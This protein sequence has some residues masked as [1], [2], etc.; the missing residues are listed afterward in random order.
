MTHPWPLVHE[1]ICPGTFKKGLLLQRRQKREPFSFSGYCY[2][3][4]IRTTKKHCSHKSQISTAAAAKSLQSCPTLSNPMDCRLPGSSIH[5]IFQ[6]RL[7]EWGA[8]A[9]S[10]DLYSEEKRI[11]NILAS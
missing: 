1:E 9:F 3:D 4:V 10:T 5:G 7:L 11:E 6:A 8:I 2:L